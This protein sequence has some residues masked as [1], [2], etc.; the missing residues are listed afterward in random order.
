MGYLKTVEGGGFSVTA[1]NGLWLYAILALPLVVLTFVVYA[2]SEMYN[3]RA[4]AR[5]RGW[6]GGAS[7]EEAARG[8]SR[9]GAAEKD[10]GNMV[11]Q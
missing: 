4:A 2:L 11:C 10:A 1:T 8:L 7:D 5:E 9:R 3:R 6:S